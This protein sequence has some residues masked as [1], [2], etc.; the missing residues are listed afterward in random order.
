MAHARVLAAALL[1]AALAVPASLQASGLAGPRPVARFDAGSSS[2]AG[3][4]SFDW[5]FRIVNQLWPKNGGG[6]D[7]TGGTGSGIDNG[8]VLDPTGRAS[9]RMRPSA[10][11][12]DN[13][14][15]L[16]PSGRA[17]SGRRHP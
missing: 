5:L 2:I 3:S 9:R 10:S 11:S 7:P 16:D 15:V 17:N 6:L 13:G 12:P 14:G 1:V 8:G 4:W